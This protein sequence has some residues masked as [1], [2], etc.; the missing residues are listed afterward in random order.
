MMDFGVLLSH[1]LLYGAIL[2]FVLSG[3]IIVSLRINPEMW[4]QDY[5]EDVQEAWGPM[6]EKA[7]GQRRW[8]AAGFFIAIIAILALAVVRLNILSGYQLTWVDVFVSTAIMTMLF[9]IVDAV[10]LDVLVML[11]LWP[12]LAILPGTEGMAGYRNAK[13]H[14]R[15]FFA[16]FGFVLV[17]SLITSGVAMLVIEGGKLLG[18]S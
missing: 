4:L 8:V 14:V 7:K 12:G 5:P 17:G 2:S 13:W 6:S 15:N 9:N 10:I 1:S 3:I 16:G 18:V 11:V